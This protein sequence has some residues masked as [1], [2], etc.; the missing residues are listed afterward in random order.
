LYGGLFSAQFKNFGTS[1][2][3]AMIRAAI[4]LR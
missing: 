2:K 3:F 1:S 4:G